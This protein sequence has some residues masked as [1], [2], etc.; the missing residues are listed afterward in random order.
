MT[1][2]RE[3]SRSYAIRPVRE[4][5][6]VLLFLSIAALGVRS[7][8]AHEH[9]LPEYAA[10]LRQA[11]A[12]H[13]TSDR[14]SEMATPA[15]DSMC[16]LT[17]KLIDS[18]TKKPLSGLA[19][20]KT[21]EG[22]VLPLESLLNRGAGLRRSH[23]AREW[24]VVI[25]SAT[26]SVPKKVLTIEALSGLETELVRKTIDLTGKATAQVAL[27][28]VHFYQPADHGWRNGNTHLHLMSMTR[29]E[30]D[31]YLR[32]IS[33]ADGLEVVFVSFL[34]RVKAERNYIS[35]TYTKRDLQKLSSGH[36][37][38]FDHAE[39]LRHN[40]GPGGEGYGHVMF[41]D[42]DELIRPVSIGPGIMGEGH[43]FPSLRP[44]I[45]QARDAGAT[46][47]WCHNAFGMQDVPEWVAGK[48]DAHNIFDG[49]TRGSYED[50]Y[51]RF[52]NIG[53]R[54]PFS[55]GTD[56]FIFDFSRAYVEVQEPLTVERWLDA[57]RAGR[58]FITNG[59][60]L[61]LQVDGH[62]PG[63]TIRLT[64]PKQLAIQG[65]AVG[66]NDFQ[67]IEIIHNGKVVAT[68]SSS[69]VKGHFE[70]KMT[71]PFDANQPGW[72]A[73]RLKSDQKNE[74]GGSLFG[75]TS[76]VYIEL[77]G[78]SV[79]KPDTARELIA[80]MQGSIQTVQEKGVFADEQQRERVLAIYRDG[81]ATL[82]KR[83]G[84]Q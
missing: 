48:L 68:E 16:R 46:V 9:T 63:D 36:G 82:R 26:A 57:L 17:L 10:S 12:D 80:D 28:L 84:Q 19:R 51:Y 18:K 81:I 35:N 41:L 71:Y 54:V 31:H 64:E 24:R 59:P 49:G 30:A 45:D 78:K 21:S 42:I 34:R 7:A 6:L 37:V 61:E 75:H 60:F 1:T 55:A 23:R 67:K 56:W 4:L 52:M 70:A 2:K 25:E 40:F 53:L 29:E 58:S 73:L 5:C 47:V 77:S 69:P 76:A 50:T 14:S 32:S 39:E 74:L 22:D 33:R 44:G 11:E 13:G 3:P 72:I 8:P 43:D 65:R 38:V 66:R 83:L 15:N 27:P 20:L 79:F 62:R